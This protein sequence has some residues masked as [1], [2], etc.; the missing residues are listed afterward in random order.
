MSTDLNTLGESKAS[1]KEQDQA[2]WYFMNHNVPRD[3]T[4]CWL[5][6]DVLTTAASPAAEVGLVSRTHET[7]DSD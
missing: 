1:S 5:V 2:P 7:R 4:L 6:A 3:Q